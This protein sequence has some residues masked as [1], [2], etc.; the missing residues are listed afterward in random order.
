PA[1]PAAPCTKRRPIR[2]ATFGEAAHTSDATANAARPTSIGRRRPYASLSGPATIWPRASPTKQA[3]S[4]SWISDAEPWRSAANAGRAGR[5]MSIES[6]AKADS[7]PR[8]RISRAVAR[9]D[10]AGVAAATSVGRPGRLV[11]GFDRGVL[12]ARRMWLVRGERLACGGRGGGAGDL[13]GRR[14]AGRDRDR[15]RERVLHPLDALRI[16]RPEHDVDRRGGRDPEQPTEDAIDLEA[17]EDGEDRDDRMQVDGPADDPRRDQLVLDLTEH[18]V[19]HDD[20]GRRGQAALGDGVNGRDA[21]RE[22]RPDE[23]DDL[24][25]PGQDPDRERVAKAHDRAEDHVH[26]RRHED[27]EQELAAQPAP[28]HPVDL[29][30]ER[31]GAGAVGDRE[32]ADGE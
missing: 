7:D 13:R 21:R 15:A 23:R 8:M 20:E 3:V 9:R 28:E 12:A 27:D 32:Q 25:D 11:G 31:H 24:E 6:G 30:Q 17:D 5:Y 19:D 14:P 18:R 22:D 16:E 29:G 26:D 10:R 2:V 4:V 1:A